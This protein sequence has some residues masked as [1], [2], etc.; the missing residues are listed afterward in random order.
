MLSS[1]RLIFIQD[2]LSQG[3]IVR[4]NVK[5]W[6]GG[7]NMARSGVDGDSEKKTPTGARYKVSYH[8]HYSLKEF[9]RTRSR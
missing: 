8:R 1:D 9:K 4:Q 7:I 2:L 3:V 6:K 5:M